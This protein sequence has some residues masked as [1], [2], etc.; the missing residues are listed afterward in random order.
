[1]KPPEDAVDFPQELLSYLRKCRRVAVLTGAGISA[2]SGVPT[3][4]DAQNGLWARFNPQ[5]LATADAFRRNPALVW[6]WYAYRRDLV[7]AARPNA[8][9]R[10]LA[11]LEA[12]FP[13]F[14]LITQNIDNLHQEAGSRSVIELHGNILR[15][16]CFD[17][18]AA[19]ETWQDETE[20][21]PRCETC[22]GLLRP[23][24]VWFGEALPR[25][26]LEKA[27]HAA[28]TAQA[29]F[30][31]GTSGLVEPAASLPFVARRSGALVVEINLERTPLS[32][33]A[34]YAFHGKAG[35]ILPALA[36]ALQA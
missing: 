11:A 24:V 21:P 14:T 29:F 32:D 12:R 16:R 33:V 2:E 23:A 3:F 4:R 25:R 27:L 13:E 35:E 8:G 18:G 31:I 10:A 28:R 15:V 1:M 6:D 30:S 22:G 20:K 19:A 26:A 7:A 36:A 9:H 34:D 5:D 17:C